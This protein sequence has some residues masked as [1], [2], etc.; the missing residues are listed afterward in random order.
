MTLRTLSPAD[1]RYVVNTTYGPRVVRVQDGRVEVEVR[2]R[3]RS[4]WLP[5]SPSTVGIVREMGPDER[6]AAAERYAETEHRCSRCGRP[7]R[8]EQSVANG[9]GP[10]CWQIVNGQRGESE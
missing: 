9:L 5:A 2:K 8:A 6:T 1:G 7:L 10:D 4:V 3:R